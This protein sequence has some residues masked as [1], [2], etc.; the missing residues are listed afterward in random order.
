MKSFGSGRR[1]RYTQDIS[2]SAWL[3]QDRDVCV[4]VKDPFDLRSGD[5]YA[6]RCNVF[7][8]QKHQIREVSY[9]QSFPRNAP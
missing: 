6:A 2:L 8:I 1:S 4:L 9:D 5:R 7:K 3:C